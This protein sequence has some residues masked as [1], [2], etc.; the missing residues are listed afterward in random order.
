MD[1]FQTLAE[2]SVAFAGFG[3]IHAVLERSNAPRVLHRAFTIVLTG[4]MSFVLSVVVLLMDGLAIQSVMLWQLA[5]GC[6]FV[7][8]S[9]GGAFFYL[10]HRKA[11]R[12]GFGPQSPVFFRIASTLLLGAVPLLF[13]NAVA[14]LWTPNWGIYATA[15]TMILASGL[16]ALLGSFWFPLAFAMQSV[17]DDLSRMEERETP[18]NAAH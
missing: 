9:L 12:L 3:A 8:T 18:D 6:G 1:F 10:G 7:L 16:F 5:S 15:L 17:E 2:C 4:S 11:S 13:L 14:W